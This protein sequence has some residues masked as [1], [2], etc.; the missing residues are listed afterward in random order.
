MAAAAGI[1]PSI[2]PCRWAPWC[3]EFGGLI[4]LP[5]VLSADFWA[6]RLALL[7]GAPLLVIAVLAML[8]AGRRALVITCGLIALGL[9]GYSA[10]VG[11]L[12]AGTAGGEVVGA[13]TGPLV[14]AL[15]LCL[16]ASAISGL[17]VT[18]RSSSALGGVFSPVA[19][20]LLVLAIFAAGVFWAAPRLMPA[21]ELTDKT[22]TAVND[23]QVLIRPGAVRTLPATAADLGMGPAASRT[24]VLSSSHEG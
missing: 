17:Q 12:A 8:A 6:L 2:Q 21:T 20:T 7:I 23:E 14:S 9:V 19:S 3:D 10:L 18:H 24:L 16:I 22:I 15:A 13:Y 5:E 11:R 4:W 1:L